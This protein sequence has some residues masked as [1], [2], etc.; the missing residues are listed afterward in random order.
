MA[1]TTLNGKVTD[2]DGKPIVG[3]TVTVKEQPTKGGITNIDGE[4][5]IML[6]IQPNTSLTASSLGYKE[7][8]KPIKPTKNSGYRINFT[9]KSS[10]LDISEVV[11]NS[12]RWDDRVA[13]TQIGAEKIILSEMAKAPTMFGEKDVV[14]SVTL[15]PGVKAQGDGQSGYMVRGG[16]VTQNL[17]LLDKAQLYST[18]HALGLFSVINGDAIAQATLYKGLIPAQFG[19]A[20]ASIFEI[21][22]KRGDLHDY[23]FG[24]DVGLLSA[25]AYAEGPIVSD[26]ASFFVSARRSYFDMFLKL[27]E[28]YRENILNFY[29][30]NANLHYKISDNNSLSLSFFNGGDNL[31]LADMFDMFW[32]N[33][34]GSLGWF[35]RYN[36]CLTSNT[37]LTRSGYSATT[38]VEIAGMSINLAGEVGQTG[39]THE[40]VHER[41]ENTL[42]F[43][44]QSYL[45]DI[46]TADWEINGYHERERR[47]GL[48][49]A[50]WVNEEWKITPRITLLAGLRL[51]L[52]TVLGGSPYY[53]FDEDGEITSTLD[54]GSGEVVKNYWSLEPRLSTNFRLNDHHSIKVGYARTSQSIYRIENNTSVMPFTRYTMA[55][56]YLKPQISDQVSLGYM[57]LTRDQMFEFSVEGYY[58]ATQ[59]AYDYKDG[60]SL[61]SE[62][63]IETLLCEGRG[64]AWGVELLAKKNKGI[65]SGW[66]G[67][68]LS[69]SKTQIDEING[70]EWYNASND[71]R[72]SISVVGMCALSRRWMV[73]ASWVYSS[74]KPISAPSAK[75]EIEGETAYYYAERNG[76]R[77][78]AY[79]RLDINFTNSKKLEKYTREWSFGV[80]NLYNQMNPF[81]IYFSDDATSPSGTKTTQYSLYGLLPSANYSIRF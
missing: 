66:I 71:M 38:E 27:T 6:N 60:K 29:D 53:T 72:H 18:G 12:R 50:A 77:T 39:I 10:S 15:L 43:G 45:A 41:N 28:D 23:S 44:V 73:A 58:K 24:V 20:S 70:G 33:T 59:N 2:E 34:N 61:T 14:K 17:I 81:M 47:K 80:Y 21:E 32:G 16:T 36:S 13:T 40:F 57:A 35:H 4:Y 37:T 7:Q 9:L 31:G 11:V 54:Y 30:I 49:S 8:T 25:K 51:G 56:N 67:Y 76:Y 3:A 68:T 64:R 75:Y 19:G 55:S 48:E 78:P 74:G 46:V 5:I 42:R 62:I 26:K 79:H 65:L 22:T 1:Q 52:F 63:E 69:W